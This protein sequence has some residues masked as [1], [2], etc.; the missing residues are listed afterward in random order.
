MT[1]DEQSNH[2][3]MHLLRLR[4]TDCLSRQSFN[5]CSRLSNA[6]AQ[7]VVCWLSQLCDAAHL[8]I[9]SKLPSYPCRIAW[10]RTG[11]WVAGV[12]WALHLRALPTRRQGLFRFD[13]LWRATTTALCCFE[14]TKLHI[15]SISTSSTRTTMTASLSGWRCSSNIVFTCSSW[16]DFFLAFQSRL[17]G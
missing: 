11:L 10:A 13:G 8:T 14:P 6:G 4:K 2:R 7:F 17:L 5:A 9:A 12:A 3:I 1:I 16:L 15:S